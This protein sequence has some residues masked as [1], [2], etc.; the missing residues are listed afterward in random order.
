MMKKFAMLFLALLLT[1]CMAVACSPDTDGTQGTMDAG[2]TEKPTEQATEPATEP[3]TEG[4]T[5]DPADPYVNDALFP[6]LG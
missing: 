6:D 2:T 3:V 1:L 5:M 4:A